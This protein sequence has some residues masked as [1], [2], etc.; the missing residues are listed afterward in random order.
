MPSIGHEA[1]YQV[2]CWIV[3]ASA[4]FLYR[5]LHD[6][7]LVAKAVIAT[8][9]IAF[10]TWYRVPGCDS[11]MF[12]YYV[13]MI[14]LLVS[15]GLVAET[16]VDKYSM[17][18]Q[19]DRARQ[20]MCAHFGLAMIIAQIGWVTITGDTSRHILFPDVHDQS[21]AVKVCRLFSFMSLS[22]LVVSAIY[23]SDSLIFALSADSLHYQCL[24][25]AHF[26]LVSIWIRIFLS[27][28]LHGVTDLVS[29][30]KFKFK[31]PADNET[32]DT[33]WLQSNI[34]KRHC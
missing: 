2:T 4:V 25:P 3:S 17:I 5:I 7:G 23:G 29:S 20:E 12:L 21:R 6:S 9:V 32:D 27:A 33:N 18:S 16:I 24:F 8:A 28:P 1:F 14:I 10:V 15:V 19:V 34:R 31:W 22:A 11:A 30:K 26:G 13:V